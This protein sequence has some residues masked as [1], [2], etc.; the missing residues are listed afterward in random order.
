VCKGRKEICDIGVRLVRADH[1]EA[2]SAF[3]LPRK[4]QCVFP[5]AGRQ[6]GVACLRQ[7]PSHAA[8]CQW[9]IIHDQNYLGVWGR[10]GSAVWHVV[11]TAN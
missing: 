4:P 3:Q 5:V 11:H 8:P 6:H 9:V 2:K 10:L 1:D 7:N